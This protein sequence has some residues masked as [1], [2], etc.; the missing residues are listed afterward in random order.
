MMRFTAL[1]LKM[2]ALFSEEL[3]CATYEEEIDN[4]NVCLLIES[5]FKNFPGGTKTAR[6][7]ISSLVKK[8]MVTV[9][10]HGIDGR[11]EYWATDK[12]L[13]SV[14]EEIV[15]VGYIYY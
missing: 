12:G 5:D 4:G 2:L 14:F 15:H 6:G 3:N 7:V 10:Y 11:T 8:G 13:K 9:D 1:E